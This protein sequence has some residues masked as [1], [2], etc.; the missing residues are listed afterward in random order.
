[1]YVEGT[2]FTSGATTKELILDLKFQAFTPF[3]I[4]RH[5]SDA[6]YILSGI[7]LGSYATRAAEGE[8]YALND[9]ILIGTNGVLSKVTYN[10]SLD[11]NV[12]YLCIRSINGILHIEVAEYSNINYQDWFWTGQPVDAPAFMETNAFT[13]GDFAVKKQVP[14]LT[15]AFAES[16]KLLI[17]DGVSQES[18]CIGRFKWDFT[19]LYRSGKWSRAQQLYRKTR[20][21]YGDEDIDTGY[22]LLVTKTKIRGTGRSFAFRVDT[23]PNKDCHIY[24]WN[25]TLTGNNV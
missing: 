14:Y 23:E 15:M 24:G 10:V 21:Y 18:S 7:Q 2:P 6:A 1:M 8:V 22:S 17:G 11:S 3:T 20:F 25:L 9:K 19:H 4:S 12:K 5:P 13:G 16:E